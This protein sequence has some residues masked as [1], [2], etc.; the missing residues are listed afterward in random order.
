MVIHGEITEFERKVE[1][2]SDEFQSTFTI[3]RGGQIANLW[4]VSECQ[5]VLGLISKHLGWKIENMQIVKTGQI[6]G[7]YDVWVIGHYIQGE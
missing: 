4:D 1:A 6:A 5:T 7:T 3:L 2:L